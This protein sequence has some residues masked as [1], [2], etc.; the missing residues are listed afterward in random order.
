M[1][2]HHIDGDALAAAF[3][4]LS[5]SEE[6]TSVRRSDNPRRRANLIFATALLAFAIAPLAIAQSS[7]GPVDGGKRNPSSDARSSYKSET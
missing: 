5:D 1:S 6:K 2:K 3:V 4:E 7:G